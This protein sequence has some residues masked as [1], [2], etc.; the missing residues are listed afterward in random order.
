MKIIALLLVMSCLWTSCGLGVKRG[1]PVVIKNGDKVLFESEPISEVRIGTGSADFIFSTN[2]LK[3][4]EKFMREGASNGL[5]VDVYL[6]DLPYVKNAP[7]VFY[8]DGIRTK[9][10]I[11]LPND[12][13]SKF[14]EA[15]FSTIR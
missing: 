6:G 9:P 5:S 12:Y 2:D 1:V 15:G 14:E 11:P 3:R 10:I 4:Y 8:S 13:E 7:I